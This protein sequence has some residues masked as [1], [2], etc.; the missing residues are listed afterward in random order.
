M[1]EDLFA[2][3]LAPE[4]VAEQRGKSLRTLRLERQRGVGPPYVHDGRSV[5]YPIEGF[6][7]WLRANERLPV[8]TEKAAIGRRF[9]EAK[10]A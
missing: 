1:N 6:R 9:T 7:A 5:R 4:Q 2:G 8:R 10:R 3:Y